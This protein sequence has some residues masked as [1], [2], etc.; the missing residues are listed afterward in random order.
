MM[1]C[2]LA[3]DDPRGPRHEGRSVTSGSAAKGATRRAIPTKAAEDV[4]RKKRFETFMGLSN[5][6]GA[7]STR[8]INV[9]KPDL[10]KLR[11]APAFRQ[12]KNPDRKVSGKTKPKS[13]ASR[14]R[15]THRNL[16]HKLQS[17]IR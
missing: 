2:P 11:A 8:A 17:L 3:P 16:R 10:K 4:F 1:S 15:P 14:R 12:I 7:A 13:L 6:D 9:A 5:N